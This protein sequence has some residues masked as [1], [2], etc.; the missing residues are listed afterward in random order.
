MVLSSCSC[1][2]S[3]EPILL[4]SDEFADPR[5]ETP[6]SQDILSVDRVLFLGEAMIA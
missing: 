5:V 2:P 4:P 6:Q 1:S 3:L